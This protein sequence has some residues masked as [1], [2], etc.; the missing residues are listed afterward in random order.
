MIFD[1]YSEVISLLAV[2]FIYF[3]KITIIAVTNCSR[4]G[5]ILIINAWI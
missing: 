3:T 4:Y 1:F 2:F 5:V